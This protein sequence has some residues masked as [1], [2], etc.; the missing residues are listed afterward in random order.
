MY[1]VLGKFNP[2]PSDGYKFVVCNQDT[3]NYEKLVLKDNKIAGAMFIGSMKNVWS[4]KQLMEGQVDILSV[5]D[6]L[7]KGI[8]LQL[9]IPNN[10]SILF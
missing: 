4:V 10:H 5:R 7:C 6:K 1:A 2:D 9:L 8:D 3:Q